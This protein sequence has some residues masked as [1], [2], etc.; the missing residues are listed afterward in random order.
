MGDELIRITVD[1]R[2]AT[3]RLG[4]FVRRMGNPL[5]ALRVIGERLVR[6]TE[7]RFN[8]Q[9]PAPDGTPWAPLAASTRRKK[10]HPKILTE[11]GQLRGSIRYQ[12]LGANAVAVGTNKVYAAIQQLGGEIVQGARSELFTRKRYVRGTKK[13]RFKKGTV[14]GQGFTFAERRIAIPARA[15]LG[16]SAQDGEE[17]VRILAQYVTE[18]KA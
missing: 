9:G 15:F 12:V 10:K 16:V 14:A 8:K 18:G 2:Q 5:A 4:E 17:L 1:D 7:D 3:A 6:Q 13:G 11:S